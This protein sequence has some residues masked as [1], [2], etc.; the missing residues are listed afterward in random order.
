MRAAVSPPCVGAS[1]W[2]RTNLP[3]VLTGWLVTLAVLPRACT[4]VVKGPALLL[5]TWMSKSRVL[6]D[7][8]SP[9]APAWR[10]VNFVSVLV[11]PRYTVRV[12]VP[13]AFEHH[14]SLLPLDTLTFIAFSG[15]LKV[16]YRLY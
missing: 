2:R 7:V 1:T 8:L 6:N 12:F 16:R 14:L 13:D 11:E 4:T 5:D 15:Y 9:P 3:L 10:T